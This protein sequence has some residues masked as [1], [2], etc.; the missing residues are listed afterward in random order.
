MTTNQEQINSALATLQGVVGAV[1]KATTEE[2]IVPSGDS[3][4]KYEPGTFQTAA[5]T[6]TTLAGVYEALKKAGIF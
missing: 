3:A 2:G 6:A 1:P 5:S 4:Q